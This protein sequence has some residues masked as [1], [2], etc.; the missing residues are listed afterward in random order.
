M[1][2]P[3]KLLVLNL[4]TAALMVAAGAQETTLPPETELT[5]PV[6]RRRNGEQSRPRLRTQTNTSRE[7]A[8]RLRQME[9]AAAKS[10]AKR[11]AVAA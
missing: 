8:R 7:Q 10:A 6:Q 11:A 1:Q 3:S 4:V 5:E 9:R 2:K